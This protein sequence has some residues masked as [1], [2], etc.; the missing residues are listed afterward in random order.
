MSAVGVKARLASC[1][2]QERA[3]RYTAGAAGILGDERRDH[4]AVPV[5]GMA[6]IQHRVKREI[7]PDLA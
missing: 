5:F 6:T 2:T 7:V 4:F 3:F 1:E